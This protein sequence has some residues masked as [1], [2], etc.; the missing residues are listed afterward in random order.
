MEQ[1]NDLILKKLLIFFPFWGLGFA[2]LPARRGVL[3]FEL[4]SNNYLILL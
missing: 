3:G 4:F 2:C 1:K